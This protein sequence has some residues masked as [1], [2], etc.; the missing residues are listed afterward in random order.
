MQIIYVKIDG[1]HCV[2]CENKIKKELLKNRKIKKVDIKNNIAYISYDGNLENKEIIDSITKIDYITKDEYIS[3]N[4]NDLNT[5]IKFR[6]FIIIS[7]LVL[8]IVLL[9]NKIFGFNIFNIIPKIDNSITYGMLLVTGLLTSIHCISMCGA[10]NLMATYND[11]NKISIKKPI[12]YNLGRVISYTFIGGIVGAIGSVISINES[13]NGIIIILAAI[14]M[15]LMSLNMLGIIKFKLPKLFKFKIRTKQ[16]SSFVIGL[17]N[18]LMPC[19]PLQAMQ[20]YALSTGSFIAGLLSMFLFS[21]GTVP[22]MLCVGVIFN[23]F[24]GK[25]RILLN[26]IAS[27]LILILS[28]VMLN[29]GFNTLGLNFSNL[30]NNYGEF[31][32]SAIKDDYQEIKIDLTYNNYDD[33]IVQ[34]DIPVRL[35]IHVE[36]KY[37]TGCNEE[38]VLSEYKIRKKLVEGDNIIEFTPTK[39]GTFPMNCWMN[40]INNTIKVIDNKDYFKEVNHE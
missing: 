25:K 33:I 20:V 26:K 11:D 14:L 40:M 12:L 8:L 27:V 2:H 19:G 15:L 22:L 1:I 3:H 39:T 9:I 36:K 16:R 29:R 37:L 23:L 13:I 28:L 4:L 34:K 6:E 7:C 17:L 18:G 21:V 38:I 31:T 5:K 35:V 24:K 30:F 10:I 32:A